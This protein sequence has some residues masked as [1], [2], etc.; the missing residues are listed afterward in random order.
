MSSAPLRSVKEAE[1]FVPRVAAE[2]AVADHYREVAEVA[3]YT[4]LE[5]RR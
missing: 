5:V 3:G 1:A 2:P 4:V